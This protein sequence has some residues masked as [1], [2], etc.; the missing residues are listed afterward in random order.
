ML[1]LHTKQQP[2]AT[3]AGGQQRCVC[4]ETDEVRVHKMGQQTNHKQK[5]EQTTNNVQ[6]RKNENEK[7][8]TS[9]RVCVREGM[10]VRVR[11]RVR[12]RAYERKG[13]LKL[14]SKERGSQKIVSLCCH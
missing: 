6:R 10:S 9:V 8:K 14:E 5:E 13:G 4:E 7:E 3:G 1:A 11:V 2:R 12:V